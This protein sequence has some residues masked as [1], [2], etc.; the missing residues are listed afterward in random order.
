MAA[1]INPRQLLGL[2]LLTCVVA[3]LFGAKP[4]AGWVDTSVLADTIVQQTADEWLSVTQRLGF[5][6]PYEVLRQAVRQAEGPH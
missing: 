2:A 1:G 3:A 6:R 5:D 4:L